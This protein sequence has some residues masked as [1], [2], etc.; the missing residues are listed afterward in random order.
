METINKYL[1]LIVIVAILVFGGILYNQN[2]NLG[3]ALTYSAARSN[4]ETFNFMKGVSQ[5]VG[6]GASAAWDPAAITTT[7]PATTTI[8]VAGAAIGD[9]VLAQFATTTS[10]ERW[11][12]NGKVTSAN[13]VMVT[14]DLND[15]GASLNL[16]S[17][18]LYVRAASSTVNTSVSA[19]P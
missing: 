15:A 6:L 13:T 1:S 3:S 9:F 10:N 17:A 8:T 2:S 7:T 18:T 19:S 4:L 16:G 11:S 5:D 12:V 14:L